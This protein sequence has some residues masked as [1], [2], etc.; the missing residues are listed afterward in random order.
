PSA[1]RPAPVVVAIAHEAAA[2]VALAVVVVAARAAAPAPTVII[3]DE[4]SVFITLG[5][6]RI[7]RHVVLLICRT[8]PQS[9][10]GLAILLAGWPRLAGTQ[11]PAQGGG[12][13]P[14]R[15]CLGEQPAAG[16]FLAFDDLA[17]HPRRD[18]QRRQ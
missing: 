10:H 18:P 11:V 14:G 2:A 8:M 16:L 4:T 6:V 9:R 13:D 17:D 5:R 3:A 7:P 15:L 1:T 12:I